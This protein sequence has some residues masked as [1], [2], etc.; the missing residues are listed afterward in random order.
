MLFFLPGGTVPLEADRPREDEGGGGGS[1]RGGGPRRGMLAQLEETFNIALVWLVPHVRLVGENVNSGHLTNHLENPRDV[2]TTLVSGHRAHNDLPP[3]K[4]KHTEVLFP[5]CHPHK[6]V[7]GN[8]GDVVVVTDLR[9]ECIAEEL[10]QHPIDQL[11]P[12]S[13]TKLHLALHGVI[14]ESHL[15]IKWNLTTMKLRTTEIL[16]T[17]AKN[18]S[19]SFI[20]D[21]EGLALQEPMEGLCLTPDIEIRIQ[22]G[23]DLF[24]SI[25]VKCNC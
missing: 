10:V 2:L 19:K 9:S 8:V 1:T 4:I 20:G 18:L 14:H 22:L 11:H 16:L 6:N 5:R 3:N 23:N 17:K 13:S 21:R 25:K 15:T 12:M 7:L 24:I